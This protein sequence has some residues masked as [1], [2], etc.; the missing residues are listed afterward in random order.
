MDAP[1]GIVAEAFELVGVDEV[2]P[3]L[4]EAALLTFT[5]GEMAFAKATVDP[6]RRLA[7]RLAAKRAACRLLGPEASLRD[8]EV[9]RGR[10][11]PRLDFSARAQALLAARGA[12]R[13]LVSLTHERRHAA[14]SVL[15]L[16]PPD[17]QTE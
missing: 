11:A 10:G 3:L 6:E 16:A 9:V 2:L 13:V 8:V 12:D 14:A 15:F 5:E 17:P 4:G 1:D 7:A